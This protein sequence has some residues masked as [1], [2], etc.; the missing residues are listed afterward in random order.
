MYGEKLDLEEKTELVC[1]RLLSVCEVQL[2][3]SLPLNS[4]DLS[5]DPRL[6]WE[7]TAVLN[8]RWTVNS[9]GSEIAS[10]QWWP[11]M[12]AKTFEFAAVVSVSTYY[13]RP[14]QSRLSS[15]T[16]FLFFVF[17]ST[18]SNCSHLLGMSI[19]S[20]SAVQTEACIRFRTVY[21]N[22]ANQERSDP[23]RFVLH[24]LSK[25]SD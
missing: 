23:V 24:T 22:S 11:Q 18:P 5:F 21:F 1:A 25:R 20:S 14:L 16:V 8:C 13:W 2:L 7:P 3:A 4:L 9:F 15:L 12:W 10:K 17:L 6:R 19:R